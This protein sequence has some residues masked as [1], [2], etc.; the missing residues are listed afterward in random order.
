LRLRFFAAALALG[1]AMALPARALDIVLAASASSP[2]TRVSVPDERLSALAGTLLLEDGSR[3]P[4][5]CLGEV[6]PL[7]AEAWKLAAS[8][9]GKDA[10]WS[11]DDLGDRLYSTYLVESRNASRRG[12][13]D[14]VVGKERFAGVESIRIEGEPLAEDGLEVWLSWEGVPELKAEIARFAAAHGKRIRAV[15]VPNTQT[16]L[17]ALARAGGELPDLVMIQSDY[18]PE[19]EAAN[20]LQSVDR[21]RD[22]GLE[23]KGY[24]A[25]SADG[26]AWATPL[27]Y[28][29]QLLFYNRALAGGPLPEGYSLDDLERRAAALKGRVK[30]PMAWNLYSAYWLLPFMAGFGKA[31][32]VD[33]DGG[34]TV[35]DAAT[36][37]ALAR[38]KGLVDSGLLVP[39]ERDAMTAWFA[40]GQAAFILSGSYS[41]PEFTRLGLDFG[42]APYP[43]ASPGGRPVAPLLDFKGLSITRRSECPVLARRLSEAL[44]CQA[45]QARFTAALGKLPASAR[46]REA[47]RGSNPY[48]AQLA[49]SAE[50]GIVVPPARAYP[51]FKN[52]MWKM[53]RFYLT[54]QMG[55]DETLSTAQRL[56]DESLKPR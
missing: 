34:M 30:A 6:A 45:F 29:A 18:L 43:L 56:I 40:S 54:G 17:L 28:D 22:P 24:E 47:S 12:S 23:A 36:K 15:E 55:L 3:A 1:F 51:V 20:L 26:H 16:K 49:R 7:V 8:G 13:W 33:S 11:A 31:A 5:L 21:F 35:N 9:G 52:T 14:L 50:T 19:L 46:A 39:A 10:S 4:G 53:L 38:L 41:I 44:A 37:A 32:V 42:I 25:F 48:F 27:Y 2:G